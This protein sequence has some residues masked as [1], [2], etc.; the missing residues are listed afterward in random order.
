MVALAAGGLGQTFTGVPDMCLAVSRWGTTKALVGGSELAKTTDQWLF[1]EGMKRPWAIAN[2]CWPALRI[3]RFA[4]GV[5]EPLEHIRRIGPSR[6]SST[7]SRLVVHQGVATTVA[8]AT[9]KSNSVYEQARDALANIDQQLGEAGTDKRH[10]LFVTIYLSDI[11]N[12]PEFNRAWDEWV[13]SAELPLRAC[14][15]VELES[16]DLVELVVTA[17]MPQA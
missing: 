11:K 9:E 10:V 4:I 13:D 8:T 15:G 17:A 7:R 12:K 2:R 1:I 5:R 16:D 6:Y 3:T 14:V